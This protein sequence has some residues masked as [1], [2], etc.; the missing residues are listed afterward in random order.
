MFRAGRS[1][2]FRAY[3]PPGLLIGVT[4]QSRSATRDNGLKTGRSFLALGYSGGAIPD[5]HRSSLFVGTSA[6]V[7]D[8]QRTL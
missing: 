8:H 6:E 5:S 3:G 4:G 2:D 7:T 1:S